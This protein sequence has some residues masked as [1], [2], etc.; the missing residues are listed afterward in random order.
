MATQENQ[1]IAS[2]NSPTTTSQVRDFAR[3]KPLEC[4]G[5]K[6]DKDPQEFYDEVYKVVEIMGVKFKEKA[7]LVAYQLKVFAQDWFTQ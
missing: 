3:M 7:E 1:A 2:P 6:L 4:Y 5:S